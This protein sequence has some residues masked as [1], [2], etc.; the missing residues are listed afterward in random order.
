MGEDYQLFVRED[1]EM[2]AAENLDGRP[3]VGRAQPV[4]TRT[5]K[6]SRRRGKG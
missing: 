1:D 6:S 4:G 5:G 3:G 2:Y